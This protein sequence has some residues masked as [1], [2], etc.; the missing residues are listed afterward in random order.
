MYDSLRTVKYAGKQMSNGFDF[1]AW[2]EATGLNHQQAASRLSVS[3]DYVQMM[4]RDPGKP[5]YRKPSQRIVSKCCEV[6]S[7]RIA[8]IRQA[9]EKWC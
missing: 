8:E 2:L 7:D 9:T 5:G 4:A 3:V 6:A 1:R